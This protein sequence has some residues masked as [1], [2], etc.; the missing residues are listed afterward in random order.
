M[1]NSSLHHLRF[2][3]AQLALLRNG[4][5]LV[6]SPYH[7]SCTAQN[8]FSLLS[9][10]V[11]VEQLCDCFIVNHG[12]LPVPSAALIGKSSRSWKEILH[13]WR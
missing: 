8:I 10:L 5:F 12:L 4:N 2:M 9:V 13:E 11:H 7:I 3:C 1:R 6:C